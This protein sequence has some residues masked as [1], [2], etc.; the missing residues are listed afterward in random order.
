MTYDTL[1]WGNVYDI[2]KIVK[3]Q[4]RPISANYKLNPGGLWDINTLK[5][6]SFLQLK[7]I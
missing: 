3:L 1:L 6:I 2:N 4:K 7:Y 5:E